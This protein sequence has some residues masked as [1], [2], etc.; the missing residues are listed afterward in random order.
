MVVTHAETRRSTATVEHELYRT[1]QICIRMK[2]KNQGSGVNGK[3]FVL[4][5]DQLKLGKIGSVCM[6][7]RILA[8]VCP[9]KD[10]YLNPFTNLI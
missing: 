8:M 4:G 9:T 1:K 3:T 6:G 10:I 7:I 2:Q 5:G